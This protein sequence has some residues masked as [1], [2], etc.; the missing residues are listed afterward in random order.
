MSKLHI[1]WETWEEIA[2]HCRRS[3]PLQALS[4]LAY[5][6]GTDGKL[7][8]LASIA[9]RIFNRRWDEIDRKKAEAAERER[10]QRKAAAAAAAAQNV[11]ALESVAH[12]SA[13]NGD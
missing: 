2:N 8:I 12:A 9:K 3:L 4:R 11:A 10:Q 1:G 6:E 7:Y 13:T 5:E